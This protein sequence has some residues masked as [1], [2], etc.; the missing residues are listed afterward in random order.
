M[1]NS[2]APEWF[3]LQPDISSAIDLLLAH[4]GKHSD[5]IIGVVPGTGLV[6]RCAVEA[7]AN[8]L[9]ALSA[10]VYRNLGAPSLASFLPFGNANDQTLD[11]L[12]RDILPRAKNVPVVAG[13]W[14]ADPELDLPRHLERLKS[15]G[16]AGVVNWPAVDFV[17]GTFRQVLEEE[18]LGSE[19]EIGLMLSARDAGLR[20]FGFA[21]TPE[22]SGR[23][24]ATGVDGMILNLGWTLPRDDVRQR[25]DR[26]QM[27]IVRLTAMLAA[28]VKSG[29]R[30]LCLAFGGPV[31]T[32]EDFERLLRHVPVDGF[33]GGSLFERLPVEHALSAAIR[34]FRSIVV[35]SD[36]G[37][38][39]AG[40]GPIVAKS[41]AMRELVRGIARVAPFDVNV[42]VEGETGC[43]KELVA[44][45][46]HRLSRRTARSFVTVNC[47]AIPDALLESELFGH[48]RG[49]FTGAD[50]RR[51]GK[52][53]LAD[54]G[55][56]F[57][58]EIADL[59]RHGQV[60]LLRA[61]QQR[62]ITTVGGETPIPV[63]VR[64]VAASNRPLLPLV[65]AGEFREDLY[66]RLNHITL[67]VPPLRERIEDFPL[68]IGDV[69]AGLR[70]R[71]GRNIRGVSRRFEAR[72]RRHHW[73]G[74]VRELQHVL[75]EAALLEDGDVLDGI[76]F[77][78][79]SAA[80]SGRAHTKI[81]GRSS[82]PSRRQTAIQSLCEADGN[83]SLAAQNLGI[84]RKTLYAWLREES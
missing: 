3:A 39:G 1:I 74:N 55:T 58:D 70:Q 83:K 13:V 19:T 80:D 45:Q 30:P 62:E 8:I 51:R 72:L 23:F 18:G 15:L 24:A 63:D 14:A 33:A 12:I 6:T 75:C 34:G 53:E 27:A 59:S 2:D 7:G 67:R 35:H 40:I 77:T 22:L 41:Q 37:N 9:F 32:P 60:A 84:T 11:L 26:L 50:R 46:I 76:R 71:L 47:G 64:V 54:G 29:R 69:V 48:E 43:G 61:L 25:G 16:V 42:C 10:G 73:P 56:L 68:L 66:Y 52:F 5:P 38:D 79:D 20:A 49:A 65:A 28:V 44:T 36:D 78:P 17:D 57:L 81:V 21:L 4:A 82:K 31:E